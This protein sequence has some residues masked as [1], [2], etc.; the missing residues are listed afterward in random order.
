MSQEDEKPYIITNPYYTLHKQP[1]GESYWTEKTVLGTFLHRCSD[2]AGLTRRFIGRHVSTLTPPKEE[3]LEGET[4]FAYKTYGESRAEVYALAAGLEREYGVKPGDHIAMFSAACPEYVL[5]SL[6]CAALRCVFVPI[7]EHSS[8]EHIRAIVANSD[9]TLAFVSPVRQPERAIALFTELLPGR[10][11][12]LDNAAHTFSSAPAN[13]NS[14]AAEKSASS[15]SATP[16]KTYSAVV[17]AGAASIGA[18]WAAKAQ[19]WGEAR[20]EDLF[21]IMY[22][23][24]TTGTP[25]GVML[26]HRNIVEGANALL[27]TIPPHLRDVDPWS[28]FS[29]L[30]L[31]HIYGLAMC[32]VVTILGGY[33]VFFSGNRA[34]LLRE[35]RET[36]PALICAVPRVY[37]KI[38]DGI[39]ENVAQQGFLLR[40]VFASAYYWKRW[41]GGAPTPLADAVFAKVRE[42]FGGNLKIAL[43]GGSPMGLEVAEFFRLVVVPEFYDG[44]GMTETVATGIRT[45]PGEPVSDFGLMCPFYNYELKIASVPDMGYLASDKPHPRGEMCLRSPAVTAGYYKDPETTARVIDKDG[46]IHTGDIVV[47]EQ[48]GKVRIIDRLKNMFKLSQGEYVSG[49]AVEAAIAKSPAVACVFVHGVS[50]QPY[51]F[52]VVVPDAAAL[53]EWAR[54]NGLGNIAENM[55]E[56]CKNDRVHEFVGAEIVRVSKEAGLKG[57][58]IVHK[59]VLHPHPFDEERDLVTSTL[60]LKRHNLRK[61]FQ[62]DF[63][64]LVASK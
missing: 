13:S 27:A 35:M 42:Q 39:W 47:E 21:V 61:Y 9:A 2:E 11:I 20:M 59:F 10:V 19:E 17:D 7:N 41:W 12:L 54:Q 5:V 31:S 14:E 6:A 40:S 62:K 18:E 29:L 51:P 4:N 15:A 57:Y 8:E 64:A 43:C 1:W 38:Y 55:V 58:E 50:T 63:D 60:K 37:E 53:G 34:R 49:E 48:P 28:Y 44:Y 36:H 25:K 16:A 52:A 22:T 26:T 33:T 56:L 32:Y 46:F 3:D 24:G 23:S 30:P 45:Q